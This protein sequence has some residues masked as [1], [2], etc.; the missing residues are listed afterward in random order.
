M[1][2]TRY[3]LENGYD[4]P[5]NPKLLYVS[6]SKNEGDW[7][8]HV[9]THHFTEL[10]YVKSGG[11]VFVVEDEEYP[12]HPDDLVIINSNISHTEKSTD[13]EALEYIALGVKGVSFSFHRN[14]S[15][16]IFN[17]K[18]LQQDL[19]FYFGSL[20]KEMEE[21]GPNY[22][23]VCQ[24]L[25]E[26]L[27]VKLMRWQSFTLTPIPSVRI[28]HECYKLKRYLEANYSQE[29][30]LD[31]LAELSY[32]NKYYLIHAFTKHFGCS[33]ISYLC[34]VRVK[35]SQELLANTNYSIAEIATSTGFSSQSYFAQVFHKSC[36]MSAS[37]Y[38]KSCRD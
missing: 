10:F 33:P 1:A 7:L 11:G 16:L 6:H 28:S 38:R 14:D 37:A 30:T 21:K 5:I 34:Q 15:H 12:I 31:S 17:C 26:I 22:E 8:S 9:H 20:Q 36:H 2:T 4:S 3:Q 35:A 29:I 13:K 25:L 19:L 27:I 23:L 32:L 18:N 24:N